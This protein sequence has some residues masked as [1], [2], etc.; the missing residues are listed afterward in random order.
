MKKNQK[1]KKVNRAQN[2][3]LPLGDR[4]VIR[5]FTAEEINRKET[6][7]III[8]DTVSKDIP[9]QG[10]VL[11]VGPGRFEDGKRIPMGVKKGDKVVFSKYAYEEVKMGE[12]KY[13]ILKE[14]NILAVIG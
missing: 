14:E 13:Y 2:G 1:A 6:F 3:L 7:G 10:E 8:P 5:P 4:V 9:E 12:E 11:A